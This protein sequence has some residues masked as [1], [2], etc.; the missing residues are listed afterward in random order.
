MEDCIMTNQ[1]HCEEQLIK[2]FEMMWGNF[3]EPVMLIHRSS[4]IIAANECCK[5]FGGVPGAKCNA[6]QPEKHKG[7]KAN[8]ALDKNETCTASQ[9]IGETS[10]TS[11]WVPVSGVSDYFVHFGI[12]TL[13]AMKAMQANHDTQ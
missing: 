6:I 2:A 3:P 11:Y 1:Q 9:K 10:M 8:E 7:C 13:D 5:A 4:T 12:G